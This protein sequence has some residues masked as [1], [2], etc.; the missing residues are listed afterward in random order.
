MSFWYLLLG[1]R[2]C[3]ILNKELLTYQ[4]RFQAI[5]DVLILLAELAYGWQD[6]AIHGLQ[7]LHVLPFDEQELRV[8]LYVVADPFIVEHEDDVLRAYLFCLDGPP[9][10]FERCALV[11]LSA[12]QV[13]ELGLIFD[14]FEGALS[15][16]VRYIL[17]VLI[18]IKQLHYCLDFWMLLC[19]F[20]TLELEQ[21]I[22]L[23]HLFNELTHVIR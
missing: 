18:A 16:L 12:I 1:W 6:D 9:V 5:Y 14:P 4:F 8:S 20:Y 13:T 11:L 3:R 23:K 2:A 19:F 7:L 22:R 10:F 21:R 17:Q 15:V